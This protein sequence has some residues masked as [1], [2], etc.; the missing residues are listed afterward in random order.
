[1]Q[2]RNEVEG[3]GITPSPSTPFTED[4]FLSAVPII[5]RVT[6]PSSWMEPHPLDQVC[7]DYAGDCAER[8]VGYPLRSPHD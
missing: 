4:R 6:T 5:R 1:M 8:Q 3:E 2:C 7:F